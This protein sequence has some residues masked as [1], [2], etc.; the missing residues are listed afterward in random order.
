MSL[1]NAS[2]Y[3]L[4]ENVSSIEGSTVKINALNP[5]NYN[6]IGQTTVVEG[7]LA[8]E[9]QEQFPNAVIGDKDALDINGDIDP[10]M[11]DYTKVIPALVGAIK[12][13]TARIEALEA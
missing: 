12:E 1:S 4:K 3:R 8:H 10:Q 6:I 11:V 7:F 13:L 5:V 2:D 9:L